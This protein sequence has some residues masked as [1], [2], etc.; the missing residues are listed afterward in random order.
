MAINY[1]PSRQCRDMEAHEAKFLFTSQTALD[2]SFE[3][4]ALVVETKARFDVSTEA[5]I[6]G[7]SIA[8]AYAKCLWT[9]L[10]ILL[11]CFEINAYRI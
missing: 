5:R 1:N 9:H 8:Y 3:W 7:I 11:L 2:H 10:V 6:S 4:T